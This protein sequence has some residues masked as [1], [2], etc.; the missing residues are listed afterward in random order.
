MYLYQQQI[1]ENKPVSSSAIVE[2]LA[3]GEWDV[4]YFAKE[5]QIAKLIEAGRI[6]EDFASRQQSYSEEM[7][8]MLGDLGRC[9]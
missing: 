6:D 3:E 8:C 9:S 2:A 5:K 7:R 1:E 4:L